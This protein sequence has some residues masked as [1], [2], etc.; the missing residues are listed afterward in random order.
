MEYANYQRRFANSLTNPKINESFFK[1]EGQNRAALAIYRNNVMS[2]LLE[3]LASTFSVVQQLLGEELFNQC[4]IGF[5]RHNLPQQADLAN[6]GKSFPNFLSQ[7]EALKEYPYLAN[8]AEIELACREV[9]CAN[10]E[11][12]LDTKKISKLTDE[13]TAQLK[14]QLLGNK[15][16]LYLEWPADDI[17]LA[18]KQLAEIPEMELKPHP[19]NLLISNERGEVE[20]ARLEEDFAFFL[21]NLALGQILSLAADKT[22]KKFPNFNL[23][24]ALSS[25]LS[26]QLFK[27]I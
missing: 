10:T 20:I 26:K 15:K 22:L 12:P 17:W 3:V 7:N 9:F 19:T 8:V 27:N 25:I 5:I 13:E 24:N 18:H 16:L 6:Y 2:S 21:S 23:S 4:A 1:G 14:F 11:S